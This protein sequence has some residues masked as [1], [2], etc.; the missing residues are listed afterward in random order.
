MRK[1]IALS[2]GKIIADLQH[3]NIPDEY[4]HEVKGAVNAPIN[5]FLRAKG[6]GTTE[7]VTLTNESFPTPNSIPISQDG[8]TAAYTP[9]V[10]KQ[11]VF[12]L[13]KVSGLVQE[14]QNDVLDCRGAIIPVGTDYLLSVGGKIKYVAG[15]FSATDVDAVILKISE[16]Q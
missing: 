14:Y 2:E 15:Q 5:T 7:F 10:G 1:A 16:I 8:K 6:D 13:A 11:Y 4:L 9:V 12:T 3:Q